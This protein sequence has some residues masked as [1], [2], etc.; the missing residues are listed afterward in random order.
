[1]HS[2]TFSSN[3][4]RLTWK[5]WIGVACACVALCV[6]LPA[7]WG[8]ME[9]REPSPDYRFPYEISND[10]WML[11]RWYRHAAA[12]YPRLVLGDSVVWGQYVAKDETLSHFLNERAG[13]ELFANLGLDGVHPAA[14]V[15]LVKYYGKDIRHK[16]VI[17]N[18]NFLWMNL[19]MQ[20]NE[21]FRLNHPDLVRQ[22]SSDFA[23]HDP[24]FS[25]MMGVA[26]QRHIRFFSWTNHLKIVYFENMTVH[27]WSIENPYANPL[28]ALTFE[29]PAATSDPKSRPRRVRKQDFP[30][31]KLEESSQW[32]SFKEMVSIL[33]SRGNDVF[34]L[35]VSF[36]PYILTEESL[37]RYNVMRGEAEGWLTEEGIAY[38]LVSDLPPEMYADASHP[39]KEGYEKIAL[40][41]H[42]DGGF[43]EWMRE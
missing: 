4:V 10:Y 19:K 20:T 14:M 40:D 41:L 2:S 17:V 32:R 8:L 15:G 42:K 29:V 25:E 23:C 38:Y 7:V 39:L 11:R 37:A 5:E 1:M 33:R 34:V 24:S 30:W 3:A 35:F 13:E 21:E 36:N 22:L 28:G 43:R 9:W 18:L 27:D 16:N 12:K 6:L 31:A 26:V